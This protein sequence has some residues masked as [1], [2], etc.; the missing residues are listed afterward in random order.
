MIKRVA[1]TGIGMIDACG[2]NTT[3]CFDNVLSNEDFAKPVSDFFTAVDHFSDKIKADACRSPIGL[4]PDED[5]INISD[6]HKTK[7]MPRYMRYGIHAVEQAL[8]MSGVSIT[9]NVGVFIS[10]ITHNEN[11]YNDL[12]QYRISPLKAVN[13]PHDAL[14][15][16]ISQH[17]GYTGQNMSFQAA[18]ATGL[19][20]IDYGMKVIDQYDYVI[21]GGADAGINQID[22]GLF[23]FLH[24]L[25]T[26][27][28][29]F[30]ENRDGF[31]MGE[32]SGVLILESEEKARKRGAN[33]IAWLHEAGHASDAWNRTAPSGEGAK[34]AMYDAIY[35][36][37]FP[38]VVNAH[39]TSTPAGDEVEHRS[40]REVTAADIY[41]VKG[42]IGHTF[43]A[44]GILE[45]IYSIL[46]MQNGVIPPCHNTRVPAFD[47]VTKPTRGEFKKTLNN[48]FGFGG[49]CISQMITIGK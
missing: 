24:A 33:V 35:A 42:K 41:S 40:I 38:D 20:T 25:G 37:G 32:G 36:G 1:V 2:N 48:S 39:G 29:P 44:A 14:C 17:Y 13:I 47:V 15:G 11:E 7:Y 27:S 16:Y 43:A 12:M 49:K 34:T 22:M 30:D 23:S 18:C 9:P 46:S 21:V 6:A 4:A 3:M 19:A 8:E 28:K 26:E 5:W 31:I 10:N 45:T